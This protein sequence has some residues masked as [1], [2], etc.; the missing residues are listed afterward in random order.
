MSRLKLVEQSTAPETPGTNQVVVYANTDGALCTKDDAGT[1]RT[2][3]A[4]N[5]AQTFTDEINVRQHT[6]NNAWSIDVANGTVV[7][8]INDAVFQFS[9]TTVFSGLVMVGS[10]V[11]GQ[12]ALFMCAGGVVVKIADGGNVYS[13]TFDTAS[14]T[15]V[16]YHAGSTEY[17]LQNKTGVTRDYSIFTIRLRAAS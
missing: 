2:Y 8:A 17:R 5:V 10:T 14:K 6:S 4:G 9:T 13:T 7:T 1:V 15:N 12:A 3:A 16:Y 11:D